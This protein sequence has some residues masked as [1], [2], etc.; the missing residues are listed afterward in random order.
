MSKQ[1]PLLTASPDA[2]T[3]L[4]LGDPLAKSEAEIAAGVLEL[5]RRRS[6]FASEEAAKAL[7]ARPKRPKPDGSASPSLIDKPNSELD[8]G[9]I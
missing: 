3:S 7:S 4:F 5:R 6:V 2:L 1:S 8:L 9:D